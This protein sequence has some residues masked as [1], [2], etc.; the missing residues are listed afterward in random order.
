MGKYAGGLIASGQLENT[1][2]DELINAYVGSFGALDDAST[3]EKEIKAIRA[4]IAEGL[5][6]PIDPENSQIEKPYAVATSPKPQVAIDTNEYIKTLGFENGQLF[7]NGH[8][9]TEDLQQ[10][11]LNKESVELIFKIMKNH[12]LLS[13]FKKSDLLIM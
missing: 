7:S 1:A 9:V 13:L 2:E 10:G 3:Q 5:K 6:Y 12:S 11:L 8:P 4:G